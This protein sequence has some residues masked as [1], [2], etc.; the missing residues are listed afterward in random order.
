MSSPSMLDDRSEDPSLLADLEAISRLRPDRV[1]RLRGLRTV[2]PE[3]ASEAEPEAFELLVFR[4][5]SSS[6]THPI[7]VDPDQ[8][9]LP[10]GVVIGTAELLRAPLN[11]TAEE[12]LA[13]PLPP[14]AFRDPQAWL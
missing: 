3:G 13:G 6:T 11:P 10:G 5:F 14:Q 12:R 7:A 4:G 8:P 2:A 1:L 9:V